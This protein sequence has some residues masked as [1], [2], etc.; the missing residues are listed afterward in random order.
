MSASIG[1]KE[2]KDPAGAAVR[3]A[4]LGSSLGAS[5][6]YALFVVPH[7]PGL[8]LYVA[9]LS[10][11]H[12]LEY[13]TTARFNERNVNNKCKSSRVLLRYTSTNSAAFLLSSNGLAYWAA[14]LLGAVEYLLRLHFFPRWPRTPSLY[15]TCFIT[16]LVL[17][18]GGQTIRSAAMIR[19][20]QSFS[21]ALAYAKKD[22]HVLVTS[23]IYQYVGKDLKWRS[24]DLH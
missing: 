4:A 14:Q 20:A 11:F 21:H 9:F 13:W 2:P 22:E 12:L 1:S 24:T 15:Y 6:I 3:A 17:V 16:G 5:L 8:P 19:A 23:G 7:R 18:V 10:L